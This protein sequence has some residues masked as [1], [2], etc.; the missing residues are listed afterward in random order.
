M[1]CGPRCPTRRPTTTSSLVDSGGPVAYSN[2]AVLLTPGH[3]RPTIPVLDRVD[4]LL[5][6][7]PPDRTD[8][9]LLSVVAAARP[10]RP[11]GWQRRRG[12]PMFVVRAPGPRHRDRRRDGVEVRD[13]TTARRPARRS[14]AS[15]IDGYP[16]RRGQGRRR[17]GDAFPDALLDSAVHPPPRPWSTASRCRPRR[18]IDAPRRRRTC[19]SR[20]RSTPAVAAASGRRSVW[21]RVNAGARSSRRS[22]SPATTRD[23]GFVKIGFLP[24]RRAS[25]CASDRPARDNAGDLASWGVRRKRSRMQLGMIG[26]G[27]MGANLVRRLMR[28][29]HDVRRL[30]RERRRGRSSSRARARPARTSLEE[31]VREARRSRARS[32][33]WCRRR[34][35]T[36]RSTKLVAAPRPGRHHHRRRQLL[37]PRRHRP[38]RPPEAEGHPLRRRRHQRRRVRARAR[39]SAS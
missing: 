32:G 29:G 28:D 16:H 19:A 4:R 8:G 27:R 33:S 2:M 37:L 31:F 24:D 6:R 9:S 10:D 11:H 13:V 18:A 3:A 12:H 26:L 21:A 17:R 39:A 7:E 38:G 20:R 14:S 5:R 23:P 22:R 15:P 34:S 36:T 1:A 25:P 30:R 35:S